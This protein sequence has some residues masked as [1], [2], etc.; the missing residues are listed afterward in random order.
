MRFVDI[1]MA[2]PGFL[3]A[4]AIVAALGPGLQNVVLAIG[5]STFP[6]LPG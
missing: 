4:L 2:L 1:L 3:L 6:P 5:V